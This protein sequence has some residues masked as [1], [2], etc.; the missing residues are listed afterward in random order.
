MFGLKTNQNIARLGKYHNWG[1]FTVT[2]QTTVPLSNGEWYQLR[3]EMRGNTITAYLDCDQILEVIDFN[4]HPSGGI[5]VRTYQSRTYYDD[6][7][8]YVV[9]GS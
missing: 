1:A 2:A 7:R 9:S 5:G 6:V 8:I 3:I 4:M